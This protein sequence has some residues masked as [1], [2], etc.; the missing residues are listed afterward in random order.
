MDFENLESVITERTKMLLLCSPHNPVGRV[1]SPDELRRLGEICVKYNILIVSD[2]IHN[3]LVFK[4]F[5]HTPLA[6]VSEEFANLSITCIA[7]SK[8][9]NL[10][11][12]HTSFVIIPNLDL[13]K[14]V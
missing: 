5:A 4:E 8:T 11:G 12:L 3:D 10:A 13:K 9:F 6:S 1:W 14:A 7:P 2:E